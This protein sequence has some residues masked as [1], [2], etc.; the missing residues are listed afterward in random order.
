MLP[1]ILYYGLC[2]G[3]LFSVI[4]IYLPVGYECNN[5][6]CQTARHNHPEEG[7]IAECFLDITGKHSRNH[8]R[9]CHERCAQRVM[10]G[11]EL[12]FGKVHHVEH[13]C[14][15]SEAVAELFN[16]QCAAYSD[17]VV[18]QAGAQI[19]ITEVG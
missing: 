9:G 16:S 11:L 18:R 13:I 17:D 14:R 2:N 5:Y 12:T 15:E 3:L 4:R 19:D 7:L 8:H 1:L 6:R 10:G